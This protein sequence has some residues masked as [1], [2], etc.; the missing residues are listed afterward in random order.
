MSQ[1]PWAGLSEAISA[2]RAELEQAMTDGHG[3]KIQFRTGPVEMEFA[4]D[5]KKDAQAGA[6]V[7][8]LPWSAS[9]EAK[10]GYAAG[11]TSRLKITLQPVD[12]HGQDQNIG[13]QSQ[14]RPK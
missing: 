7:S 6:K 9:A 14:Q 1:E 3:H 12:E 4:V 8:I 5:V 10:A 11:T 13:A 2:I